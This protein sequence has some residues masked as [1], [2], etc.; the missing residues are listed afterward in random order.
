MRKA[1]SLI[2]SIFIII[3]MPSFAFAVVPKIT[4]NTENYTPPSPGILV[5][6]DKIWTIVFSKKVDPNSAKQN[7][8][9]WNLNN[10]KWNKFEIQSVVDGNKVLINHSSP[11]PDGQYNLKINKNIRSVDKKTMT[12]DFD[13]NFIVQT[14]IP[15]EDTLIWPSEL[16]DPP[17]IINNIDA[18]LVSIRVKH[19]IYPKI[20][21]V[22]ILGIEAH[23]SSDIWEICFFNNDIKAPKTLQE[24]QGK[25]I[26][27]YKE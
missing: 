24:L 13:L 18:T 15:E 5:L 14:P 4:T 22:T 9:L 3:S 7:I 10:N 12:N 20:K 1:L 2:L 25:I 19:D 17:L 6:P 26:I 11:Y 27:T 23:Q 16:N 8:S 21:S